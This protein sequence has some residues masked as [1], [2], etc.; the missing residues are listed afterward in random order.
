M[1]FSRKLHTIKV[2]IVNIAGSQVILFQKYYI[3]S[4][5][6]DFVLANSADPDE[7]P[8]NAYNMSLI[9]TKPVFG[10]FDKV[11]FKSVSSATETS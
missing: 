4:L 3:F 6:I 10:V 9:V 7:M 8:H 11:R 5:K 2:S 1:E